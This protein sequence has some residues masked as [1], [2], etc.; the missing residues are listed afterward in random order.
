MIRALFALIAAF[1]ATASAM[2]SAPACG[3]GCTPDTLVAAVYGSVS[4]RPGAGW[5]WDRV[6]DLFY[7]EGLLAS[8][9]TTPTGTRYSVTTVEQL[10]A[11]AEVMYRKSGFV[12]R[13]IRREVRLFGDMASVYSSFYV[14]IRDEDP[15][16]LMRG[17][18][19][20]QLLRVDGRWRIV[21]NSAVMEGGGWSLPA[22][23]QHAD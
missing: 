18:H 19:H 17:L 5:N 23:F 4:A 6:R 9:M 20:F 7:G 16:P 8:V 10:I 15:K 22:R 13:E 11:N 3:D 12:E 21:S 2:A 1:G 14:K